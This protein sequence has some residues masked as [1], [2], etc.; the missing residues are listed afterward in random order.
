MS[1]TRQTG[2]RGFTIVE[3]LIVIVV[4]AI[5]AAISIVAYTGIQSRAHDTSV[6]NDLRNFANLVEMYNADR[7]D[8]PRSITD[9]QWMHDNL[10]RI[11]ISK[12]SYQVLFSNSGGATYN[13]QYC[14]PA[15]GSNNR[16]AVIARSA[17]GKVFVYGGNTTGEF[18]GTISGTW[19]DNCNNVGVPMTSN[20]LLF[21]YDNGSWRSWL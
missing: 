16:F 12:N 17:S 4:I 2:S 3:L 6:Q 5:L 11:G 20:Q 21:L 7:G 10:G 18:T 9:V 15:A 8:Y 13:F 1:S 14:Y 19:R